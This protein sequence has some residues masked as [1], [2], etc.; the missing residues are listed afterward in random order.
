MFVFAGL[1]GTS[2]RASLP[3]AWSRCDNS[4]QGRKVYFSERDAVIFLITQPPEPDQAEKSADLVPRPALTS[5]LGPPRKKVL[6][7]KYEMLEPSEMAVLS[8]HLCY[9]VLV[10]LVPS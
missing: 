8:F 1:V 6:I 5:L 4:K 7:T 3:G 10:Q 2:D 9:L